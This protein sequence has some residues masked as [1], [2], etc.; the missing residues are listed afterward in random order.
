MNGVGRNDPATGETRQM[1]SDKV[2]TF[3]DGNFDQDIKTGVVLVDFWAEWCGPCRRLAPTVEALAGEFD[4][5]ATVGKLNVDENPAV[6]SR[7]MI[8]GIPTLLL[9]KD[10]ELAETLVGL[11]QKED[12]ASLIEKHLA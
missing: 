8:R 6:P 10:G 12:I 1:A 11:A 7:F 2:Q 5:R 9:F 4:G 3:T